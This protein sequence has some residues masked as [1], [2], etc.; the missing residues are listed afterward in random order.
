MSPNLR[1]Y[2]QLTYRLGAIPSHMII[3]ALQAKAELAGLQ[4]EHLES[5]AADVYFHEVG[6]T[7]PPRTGIKLA[8]GAEA[9]SEQTAEILVGWLKERRDL[10]RISPLR[11]EL[12]NLIV[13][14]LGRI[15]RLKDEAISQDH[16][17]SLESLHTRLNH[18]YQNF[19]EIEVPRY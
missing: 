6:E 5:A 3:P 16:L 4:L 17:T 1:A 12:G 15:M 19:D 9:L 7:L 8:M 14:L 2:V 18:L 10:M 13:I 11:H